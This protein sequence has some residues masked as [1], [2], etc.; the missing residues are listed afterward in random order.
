MSGFNNQYQAR[1]I[2]LKFVGWIVSAFAF[3]ISALLI[4]SLQ[5]ISHEDEVVNETN[6]NYIALKEASNDVQVASD[7]L[8]DQ[9]RLFVANAAPE[10]M[11]NYFKEANET[12][13][14]EKALET[15]HQLSVMTTRHDEIH[16][17]IYAAVEKSVSLMDL[18]YYAMKLI[19]EDQSIPYTKYPEIAKADITAIAPENRK[20]EALNAVLGPEYMA[21][22]GFINT[23]VDASVKIIDELMQSNVEKAASDLRNLVTF[24]TV[25]IV[26]NVIFMAGIIVF[27]Y[28]YVI[29]P[30]NSTIKSLLNNEDVHINS[31]REFNYMADTYN[32]VRSQNEHVKEKLIYEA[33]HDKL[34]GLYNRTGYDTLYRRMK[35]N[36]TIYILLDVDKFKEVND[37]YG[38]EMGDKVLVRTANVLNKYFNDDDA[39]VFRIGGD[40]FAIL[41]ENAGLEMNDEVINRCKKMDKELSQNKGNIPGTSLS[42]GV[43]HG[44]ENDTTDT[45]FRKADVALYK[46]KQAGKADV[47][48]YK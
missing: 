14:R 41:V 34:T 16:T 27:M 35:L 25:V 8:T 30:M 26:I 42:I 23:H 28:V 2:S 24:Q 39:Y 19:C 38:H 18:E 15:I 12:K 43:A 21:S 4:V 7:Y 20:K 5:L 36:R 45:L 47:T 31:S 32:K 10:Y 22:K 11:D 33:E 44:D 6:R 1:G 37:T 9:V 13:R 40:E 3:I 46:V 17:N 29:V 48:L